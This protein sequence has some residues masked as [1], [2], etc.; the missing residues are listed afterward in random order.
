MKID[1]QIKLNFNNVLI[2]PKRSE[3]TSRSQ[4]DLTRTIK[5]KHS[6][7]TWTGVPILT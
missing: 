4:V 5:F 2:K 7:R 6:Q 3:L 1:P